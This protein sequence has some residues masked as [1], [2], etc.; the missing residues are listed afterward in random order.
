MNSEKPH[1]IR[2]GGPWR[3][4]AVS[5]RPP[6]RVQEGRVNLNANPSE[7]LVWEPE[8]VSEFEGTVT[9]SRQFNCPTGLADSQRLAIEIEL[10]IDVFSCRGLLNDS[11]ELG[12]LSAEKQ[13]IEIKTLE[14][15]NRLQLVFSVSVGQIEELPLP[16]FQN[17]RLGI[18]PEEM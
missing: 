16:P 7:C 10:C 12:T 14:P 2:L 8:L 18:W 5:N 11:V 17:V 15:S 4:Q 3:F 6:F 1:W 9:W 13:L